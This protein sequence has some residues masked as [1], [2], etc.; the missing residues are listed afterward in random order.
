MLKSLKKYTPP[1]RSGSFS[2]SVT[3]RESSASKPPFATPP[4]GLSTPLPVPVA[5]AS[6]G[7]SY[8]EV[9][10]LGRR[11]RVVYEYEVSGD[12]AAPPLSVSSSSPTPNFDVGKLREGYA[13]RKEGH[14][15]TASAAAQA[16]ELA[17]TQ[18]RSRRLSIE[19]N[20]PI[21][22]LNGGRP[23][24]RSASTSRLRS[25]SAPVP[26]YLGDS[27]SSRESQ[28]TP[29]PKAWG[30][31]SASIAQIYAQVAGDP[32]GTTTN[33]QFAAPP[34]PDMYA[35][36]ATLWQEDHPLRKTFSPQSPPSRP[37]PAPQSVSGRPR[38]STPAQTLGELSP[39]AEP[40][41]SPMQ[42]QGAGSEPIGA[43]PQV[44]LA[45][46]SVAGPDWPPANNQTLRPPPPG[47][48]W[49]VTKVV[50]KIV[51]VPKIEF[52]EKVVLQTIEKIV[53][54]P[55][56][57]I[58]EK[59]VDRVVEKIVE[60]PIERVVEKIVQV[61]VERIK[62]VEVPVMDPRVPAESQQWQRRVEDLLHENADLREEIRSLRHQ[63]SK[64]QHVGK[65][66]VEV[67]VPVDQYGNRIETTGANTPSREANVPLHGGSSATRPHSSNSKPS[68]G[69]K[70]TH[71]RVAW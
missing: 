35:A 21:S 61:P 13:A 64:E 41:Q 68:R 67:I 65:T 63:L 54:V 4:A 20:A 39:L 17:A 62:V 33:V 10:E 2:G 29:A 47:R 40:P 55:V 58:V 11:V 31:P 51:E 57:R 22:T 24:Q 48:P 19:Q 26:S 30:P 45:Q 43:A 44:L 5:V 70:H 28:S 12:E 18:A 56:E 36:P 60:V 49:V 27:V 6:D 9:D 37:A 25:E 1:N 14:R 42:S 32:E 34:P 23:P 69:Q 71:D 7:G 66:V 8:F 3:P 53:E 52:V 59:V 16:A 50:E 38:S 46:L 15:Q